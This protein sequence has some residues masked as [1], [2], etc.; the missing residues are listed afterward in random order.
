MQT[1]N[2]SPAEFPSVLLCDSNPFTTLESQ[3]LLDQLMKNIT[4]YKKERFDLKSGLYLREL[5]FSNYYFPKSKTKRECLSFDAY[6]YATTFTLDTNFTDSQRKALGWDLS[7][8]LI[9]CTFNGNDCD[10][11]ND[12]KWYFSFQYGNCYHFNS[13]RRK[14]QVKK[15][16]DSILEKRRF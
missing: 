12:F 15:I 11:N 8:V 6:Q 1:I 5:G 7:K 9:K 14:N 2:E 13:I 16:K 3:L 4:D 10:I